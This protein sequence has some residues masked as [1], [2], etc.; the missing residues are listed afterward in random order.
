LSRTA[1]LGAGGRS[2]FFLPFLAEKGKGRKKGLLGGLM[3]YKT[4]VV[5]VIRK[6]KN[7]Y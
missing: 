6:I 5:G 3:Q 2:S 1:W 7:P 4:G